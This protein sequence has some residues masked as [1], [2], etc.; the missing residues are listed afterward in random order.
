M[1]ETINRRLD[2]M[3]VLQRRRRTIDR[4]LKVVTYAKGICV[5]PQDRPAYEALLRLQSAIDAEIAQ[6]AIVAARTL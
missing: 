6:H 4:Q 2:D 3:A 1:P 5:M